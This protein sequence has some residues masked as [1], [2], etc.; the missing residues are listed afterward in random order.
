M[1]KYVETYSASMPFV[2][3]DPKDMFAATNYGGMRKGRGDN[4]YR[5]VVLT[6]GRHLKECK[7]QIEEILGIELVG[8]NG[9]GHIL[10]FVPATRRVRAAAVRLI[11]C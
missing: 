6:G 8:K 2:D 7:L 4:H 9:T 5:E 1:Q 10:E 11:N 3:K